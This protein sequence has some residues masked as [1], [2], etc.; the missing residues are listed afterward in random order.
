LKLPE[1][2]EGRKEGQEGLEV[3]HIIIIMEGRPAAIEKNI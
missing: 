1:G 3:I 2:S